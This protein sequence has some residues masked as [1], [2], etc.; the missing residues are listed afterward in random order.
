MSPGNWSRLPLDPAKKKTAK[1]VLRSQET[2]IRRILNEWA[3][4]G[5]CTSLDEYDCLIH[6]LQS[7]LQRSCTEGDVKKLLSEE[8]TNHFGVDPPEDISDVARRVHNCKLER[9][10]G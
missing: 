6:A 1:S 10:E 8:L 9:L 5:S 3:P 7:L 4:I 2:E